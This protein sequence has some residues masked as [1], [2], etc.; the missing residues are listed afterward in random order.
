MKPRNWMTKNGHILEIQ[1]KIRFQIPSERWKCFT[2]VN[3]D[4]NLAR[5]WNNFWYFI[6]RKLT[7]IKISDYIYREM[8]KNPPYSY[9]C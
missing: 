6:R 5:D 7:I 1:F 9:D 8:I 3:I 4:L 2:L